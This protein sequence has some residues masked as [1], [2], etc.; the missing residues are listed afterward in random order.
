ML[1]PR[2]RGGCPMRGAS[3]LDWSPRAYLVAGAKIRSL[4]LLGVH[5]LP[6]DTPRLAEVSIDP[7]ILV[8]TAAHLARRHAGAA[9]PP[10]LDR[11][12][13]AGRHRRSAR[14]VARFRPV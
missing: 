6:P 8:F 11:S 1:A 9:G 12:R 3:A 2:S 4:L 14:S 5:L 10:A 7:R 13:G